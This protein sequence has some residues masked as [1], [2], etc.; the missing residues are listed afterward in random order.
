MKGREGRGGASWGLLQFIILWQ[1]AR[2]C[3]RL[4]D[5]GLFKNGEDK[6]ATDAASHLPGRRLAAGARDSRSS[7][8]LHSQTRRPR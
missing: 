2:I 5:C 1:L 8:S 4:F 7:D 3:L 6:K